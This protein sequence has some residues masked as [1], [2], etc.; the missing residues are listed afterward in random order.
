MPPKSKPDRH[1]IEARE[2]RVLADLRD[3]RLAHRDAC[4]LAIQSPDSNTHQDAVGQI[5]AEIAQHELELQRIAAAKEA[6]AQHNE[7][8]VAAQ[9]VADAKSAAV[10]CKELADQ[11]RALLERLI[12][13]FS[14]IAPGLAELQACSRERA[15]LAWQSLRSVTARLNADHAKRL[16][17]LTGASAAQ[18]AL[19]AAIGRSGLGSIGPSLTPFVA[20]SVPVGGFGSPDQALQRHEALAGE[21]DA[22]LADAI[23]QAAN[24]KPAEIEE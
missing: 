4:L 10:K 24:P 7:V 2:L 5:E 3:A 1:S 23:E 6:R 11:E 19:L 18:G 12:A 13:A 22:F 17:R 14:D 8:E 15:N 16:D 9:R 20:V 21:L